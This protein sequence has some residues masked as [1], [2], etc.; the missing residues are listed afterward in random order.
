[1]LN[2]KNYDLSKTY[3]IGVSGGPDSMAL[4][5]LLIKEK[6]NL[7][8]CHCNY[9]TRNE[10]NKEEVLVK[11]FCEKNNIKFEVHSC[12]YDEVK[13]NFEAWAREERYLFF[14][15]VYSKYHADGVFIAHHFDDALETYLMQKQR[16]S[17]VSYFG[18][19][20]ETNIFGVTVY[21]PLLNSTKE[22]LVKYCDDNNI[23]YSIDVTNLMDVHLRNRIRNHYLKD[24]SYEEKQELLKQMNKDNEYYQ[25]KLKKIEKYLTQEK[26]NINEFLFLN[27]FQRQVIIFNMIVNKIPSLINKISYYRINEFNRILFCSKASSQARLND[28][29]YFSKEYDYF[30][31]R[32]VDEEYDYSYTLEKPGKLDTK[33]FSCDFSI[34]TSFLKITKDSYPLTFRNVKE[35]DEVKIGEQIKKVNRILIDEK[36]PYISRKHYPVVTDNKGVIVYIPLFKSSRQK[37]IAT[38]LKFVIK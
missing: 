38:K 20:E 15:E 3:L 14:K 23:P 10:S 4:L 11:S 35:G 28:E 36:I 32:K 9:H 31:I 26:I 12:S 13:G 5:D 18:L 2:I 30:T 7:I 1:M 22:E 34:D 29:Y 27:E 24:M 25:E 8:V 17:I 37:D 19:K 33:E 6:L 21:R 16:G